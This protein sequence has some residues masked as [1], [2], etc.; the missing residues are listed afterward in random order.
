MKSRPHRQPSW[1]DRTGARLRSWTTI[2]PPRNRPMPKRRDRALDIELLQPVPKF[3]KRVGSE[4]D[5][6]SI[7][8]VPEVATGAACRYHYTVLRA[9]PFK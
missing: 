1:K 5:F 4:R 8:I 9:T 3:R 6:W 2:E 7:T